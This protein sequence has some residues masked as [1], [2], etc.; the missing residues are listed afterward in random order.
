MDVKGIS[1]ESEITVNFI[2][3]GGQGINYSFKAKKDA[4]TN[5]IVDIPALPFLKKDNRPCWLEVIIENFYFKPY[6][7]SVVINDMLQPIVTVT[8]P[9]VVAQKPQPP[10][11]TPTSS[12]TTEP[13]PTPEEILDD[14]AAVMTNEESNQQPVEALVESPTIRSSGSLFSKVVT[15]NESVVGA[16]DYKKRVASAKLRQILNDA[17]N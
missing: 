15:E 8:A 13:I 1:Q 9:I 17:K 6:V 3:D 14:V 12:N 10:A 7:S 11:A 4:D 2:I 16:K 5:W